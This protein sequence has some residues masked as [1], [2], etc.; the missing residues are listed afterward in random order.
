MIAN[1]MPTGTFE[2]KPLSEFTVT[3]RTPRDRLR[4][5]RLFPWLQQND[6]EYSIDHSSNIIKVFG[7]LPDDVEPVLDE[8][9]IE[10]GWKVLWDCKH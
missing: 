4:R 10:D 5:T 1:T 3:V 2:L 8:N 6:I 9:N 7:K